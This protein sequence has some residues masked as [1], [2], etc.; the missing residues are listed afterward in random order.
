MESDEN[1][2]RHNKATGLVSAVSD[3]LSA[4]T[5]DKCRNCP[6]TSL[7]KSTLSNIADAIYRE[8]LVAETMYIQLLEIHRQLRSTSNP[9]YDGRP[10]VLFPLHRLETRQLEETKQAAEAKILSLKE[11]YGHEST[12]EIENSIA[13]LKQTIANIDIELL[14]RFK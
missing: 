2:L 3:L 14:K 10:Q 13:D 4:A 7:D 1:H 12:T 9:V 6:V 8:A 5:K 11:R